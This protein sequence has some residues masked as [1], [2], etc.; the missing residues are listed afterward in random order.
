MGLF[1]D[2][3]KWNGGDPSDM[4]SYEP[5]GSSDENE[6]CGCLMS[7]VIVFVLVCLYVYLERKYY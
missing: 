7:V 1:D 3:Y 4:N 2:D 5:S 6:G